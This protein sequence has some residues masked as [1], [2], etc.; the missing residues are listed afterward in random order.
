MKKNSSIVLIFIEFLTQYPS[1]F[2]FLFVLL[3]AEGMAAT[4]SDITLMPMADFML[5]PSLVSPSRITKSS[6]EL[7]PFL[8]THPNFWIFGCFFV[9]SNLM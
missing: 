4:L 5:D 8:S 2:S 1:Q 9:V 6:I 3:V 7:L